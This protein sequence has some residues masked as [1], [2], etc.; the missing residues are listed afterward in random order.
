MAKIWRKA[1]EQELKDLYSIIEEN[2]IFT[3]KEICETCPTL[4]ARKQKWH[5]LLPEE[6]EE[7]K[8]K[9]RVENKFGAFF[10]SGGKCPML[11]N[12]HCSIY[13]DRPLECRLS[14]LSLYHTGGKLFWIIDIKCPYFERYK[15]EKKFWKKADVFISK[16]E[17]FFTSKI[18]KDLINISKAIQKFDSLIENKDFIKIREY[19]KK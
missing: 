3:E 15:N 5:W 19:E 16:I 6:A 11:K 8:G 12:T 13:E 1:I 17:P 7:L 10:F 4:C 9:M 14:P 18:V 2:S